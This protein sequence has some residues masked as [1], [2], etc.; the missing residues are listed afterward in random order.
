M[1]LTSTANG[2]AE[3]C[4]EALLPVGTDR[5]VALFVDA[6]STEV[7][8]PT[9]SRV[10]YSSW[11]ISGNEASNSAEIAFPAFT[12]DVL[13]THFGIYDAASGGNLLAVSPITSNSGTPSPQQVNAGDVPKFLAGDLAIGLYDT[14]IQPVVGGS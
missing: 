12:G 3:L 7:S 1:G 10:A 5:H 8:D 11:S 13:V 2:G 6:G 14:D 9:Y 4:L